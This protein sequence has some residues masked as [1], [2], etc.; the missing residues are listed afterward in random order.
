M[1]TMLITML[2]TMVQCVSILNI[3][4]AEG[5]CITASLSGRNTAKSCIV[6]DPSEEEVLQG[7]VYDGIHILPPDSP[8][9]GAAHERILYIIV[10]N[11]AHSAAK[12]RR[13][14]ANLLSRD[15]VS[16]ALVDQSDLQVLLKSTELKFPDFLL[17][18][19]IKQ[20]ESYTLRDGMEIILVLVGVLA[21]YASCLLILR[22]FEYCDPAMDN[23]SFL[24]AK[25]QRYERSTD[26]EHCSICYEDFEEN[27]E[28]RVLSCSH[29]FHAACVDPW[30]L[31][32]CNCCPYCRKAVEIVEI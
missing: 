28:V 12:L 19:S 13:R 29:V 22:A 15:S 4:N 6:Y 14:H 20:A 8:A 26:P 17:T 16:V 1:Q 31:G 3:E 5:C 10:H 2:C 30:L 11:P 18:F 24:S 32:H 21:I 7:S 25:I 9:L 23:F 27:D